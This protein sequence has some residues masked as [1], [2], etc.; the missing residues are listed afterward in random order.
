MNT[1]IFEAP[2]GRQRRKHSAQFKAALIQAC[3]KPGISMAAVALANGLNANMLRK[4][5]KEARLVA[6]SPPQT[7]LKANEP[8]P[9]TPG[10]VALRL[11]EP[12][13]QADLCPSIH[14]ELQRA[15][16]TIKLTWP[17]ALASECA[18]WLREVL[19]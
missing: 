3:S 12:A 2:A 18:S 15:E 19:R 14:L 6:V 4:W 13:L 7:S 5:V 16:L 8:I 9:S 1:N 11:P 10:F 17:G